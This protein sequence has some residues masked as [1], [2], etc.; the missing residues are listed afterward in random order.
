[1]ISCPQ[2]KLLAARQ[3]GATARKVRS[4]TVSRPSRRATGGLFRAISGL[5]HRSKSSRLAVLPF[6]PLDDQYATLAVRTLSESE[7]PAF[8]GLTLKTTTCYIVVLFAQ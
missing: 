3:F 6:V 1:V 8:G 5:V 2:L 4:T 7:I